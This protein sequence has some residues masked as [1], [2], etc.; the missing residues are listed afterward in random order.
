[1]CR[2]GDEISFTNMGLVAEMVLA[3]GVCPLGGFICWSV[4][5]R[6]M[7]VACDT[8]ANMTFVSRHKERG[9]LED[10]GMDGG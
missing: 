1:M 10:L 5:P 7:G 8:F 9:H 2:G 6:A 4:G 3:Q